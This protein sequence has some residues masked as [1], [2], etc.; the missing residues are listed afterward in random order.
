[1]IETQGWA[2]EAASEPGALSLKEFALPEPLS[3]QVCVANRII[4]F[5]PVDWKLIEAG[6]PAW[7]PG[8]I[9]GVDAMGT[10]VG[11]GTD[12]VGF[13]VGQRVAFHTDLRGHGTFSR[14]SLVPAR[15]LMRVPDSVSDEHAAAFPCPGLT[16]WLALSKLPTLDRRSFL[17]TG[18]GSNVARF[19]IPMAVEAGA[20]VFA[21]ASAVHH[22]ALLSQGVKG[23]ADY[24]DQNWVEALRQQNNG[25]P[26]DVV[27]DLV[28]SEQATRLVREIAY[29]GHLVAVLG[30]ADGS[31]WP[32]FSRCI[33]LHEVALGAQHE[34][35]SA[36]Q[37]LEMTSH[38]E[39]MMV[40]FALGN[41]SQPEFVVG[42][43]DRLPQLLTDYK[44]SGQG[45]KYLIKTHSM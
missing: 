20:E 23:V 38:G 44:F 28:S 2:W 27:L 9:P 17:V 43:F 45:R 1:M 4:A 21:S 41:F 5:N 14:H 15:A 7:K 3:G 42:T 32:P 26:F 35:G 12:V 24:H 34:H 37:W 8:Q 19:A 18:A 22:R 33:S 16:A 13:E 10:I 11:I 36:R 31:F 39:R 29:S 40:D 6:H 25:A 30:R